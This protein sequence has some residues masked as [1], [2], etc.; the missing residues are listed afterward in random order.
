MKINSLSKLTVKVIVSLTSMLKV[1][2]RRAILSVHLY[3]HFNQ[4]KSIARTGP[5]MKTFKRME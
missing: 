2:I 4:Q 3:S 5:S 1:S